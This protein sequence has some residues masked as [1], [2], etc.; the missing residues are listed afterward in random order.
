ME[1]LRVRGIGVIAH[2]PAA[3]GAR[4]SPKPP[5][6]KAPSLNGQAMPN[7]LRIRNSH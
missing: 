4:S 5:K 1:V 3:A 6:A 2:N 7:N